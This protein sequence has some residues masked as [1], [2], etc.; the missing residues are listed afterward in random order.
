MSANLLIAPVVGSRPQA[1]SREL[2]FLIGGKKRLLDQAIIVIEKISSKIIHLESSQK[3]C[4]LKLTINSLFGIQTLAF[5]EFYSALIKSDFSETELDQI[6]PELA[7]TSPMMKLML[8]LF[9]KKMYAPL[10][11]INL[12]KK[13]LEY[14][15]NFLKKNEINSIATASA[16]IGFERAIDQGLGEQNISGVINLNNFN[17]NEEK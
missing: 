15:M 12:V 14:A 1:E 10:F 3:A 16:L 6:L 4:A 11:P 13:D 8:Q 7:V 17:K 2:I 5:A 9:R